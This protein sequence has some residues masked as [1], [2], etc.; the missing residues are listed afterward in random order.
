MATITVLEGNKVRVAEA[1]TNTAGAAVD[2][3]A[4]LFKYEDPSGN[5]ITLTYGIDAALVKD[6]VGNYHVDID[7]DE[8][9]TWHW[10]FR[11]TGTNQA[12]DEDSFVV[13]ASRFW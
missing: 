7:C 2:P 5:I 3:T 4:V 9:G 13:H 10:G 8:P 1:F 12:A 6:S 11:G